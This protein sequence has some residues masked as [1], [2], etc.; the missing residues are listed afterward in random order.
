[1]SEPGPDARFAASMGGLLGPGFPS[2]IALAVSGG[3]DSMAMLYLAHNWTRVWGVRLWVVTVDHGLRPDSAAEARMVADTCRELGWPHATL[4]WH[5]DAAG[6]L[7]DAARRG[8]LALIDR[9][10]GGIRHVLFAH[11]RDD[12]AE[13]FLMRLT[14]GSGV[15]GLSAMAPR[16]LVIPHGDTPPPLADKEIAAPT[17]P[18]A[19]APGDAPGFEVI[20]PLLGERRADLRFYL[21]VLKGRWAEDPSNED[22]AFDRARTRRLLAGLEAEGLG[23]EPLAAT[24]ERLARARLALEARAADVAARLVRRAESC[25]VPT[26]DLLLDRDGFAQVETDTQLR[27]L[28]AALQWVAS[29]PYRPR[30]RPLEALLDR[31]LAG[32]GGTLHG[33]E[34]RAEGA[35]IRVFR[36]HAALRGVETPALAGRRWDAR[37][38]VVQPAAAHAIRALGPEGWAQVEAKPPGAPPARA[39]YALPAL[40]RDGRLV[41]CPALGIGAPE[42]LSLCPPR[43]PAGIAF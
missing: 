11:T 36:E 33:C 43:A 6:N 21:R 34:L 14:R 41:A 42:T 26:G 18:P 29:A 12:I 9:W 8:R 13:T 31:L 15:E 40:F 7:Q 24:A 5:W 28:A 4:Y 39:S 22:P 38:Q 25:G 10:R 16:R 35:T 37:W 23:A 27:L 20:R 1:M 32:G 19:A 17:R 30:A 3:G 2:D